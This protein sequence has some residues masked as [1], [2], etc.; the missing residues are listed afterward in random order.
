MKNKRSK[1]I[2]LALLVIFQIF[3]YQKENLA[4]PDFEDNQV[5]ICGLNSDSLTSDNL[6]EILPGKTGNRQL[7][8]AIQNDVLE[9]QK[10]FGVTAKLF[11]IQEVRGP[12]ALAVRVPLPQILDKFRVPFQATPD[13]MVFFGTDLI[14]SQYNFISKRGYAIPSIISHEYAHILQYKLR[15]PFTGKWQELHA[16][17]LAGWYT[18]HRSR[19]MPQNIRESMTTFFDNGDNE[20]NS[21]QHH[22]SSLE[23]EE[24]FLAGVKLNQQNGFMTGT[25]VYYQG[26]KYIQ[27]KG[28]GSSFKDH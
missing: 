20:V 3:C 12:N 5:F 15:F 1:P 10:V 4:R 7:D 26:I 23:R 19:F 22:G 6:G 11:L 14:R 8:T 16:D 2:I 25:D 27:L 13:G 24:A 18:A 21:P 17:F 28:A 9:L